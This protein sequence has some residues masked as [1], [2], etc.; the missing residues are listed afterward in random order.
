MFSQVWVHVCVSLS[1]VGANVTITHDPSD[2]TVQ[3]PYLRP[4]DSPC[5]AAPTAVLGPIPSSN[6]WCHWRPFQ[7]CSFGNLMGVTFGG[8]H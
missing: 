6:I 2:L 4:P 8:G 5:P 7:T 1:T 3:G